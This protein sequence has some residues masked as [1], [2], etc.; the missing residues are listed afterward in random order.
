MP[1][2]MLDLIAKKRDGF[3]HSKPELEFL[4]AAAAKGSV[5]DY[6]LSAW[7]M[8]VLQRGMKRSE[9]VALTDAMARSGRTL[10]RTSRRKRVDKHSTGGVGDGVSLALA[11]LVAAAGVDVPM[12]S[13]RG[14]G[15]TGGTLDKLESIRGLKVRMPVAKVE[16]IVKS[17]GVC[18]F[19]QSA[20]L[21]PADQKL[22]ALRDAT[23]TVPARPLICGSI[24]SKKIAENLDALVL[25][26]KCGTGAIFQN[27]TEAKSLAEDLIATA[28]ELGLRC[29]GLLTAM[30]QP[31]GRTVGNALEL[32]QA[33]EVLH[34]DASCA[35]YVELTLTLG[36]W[37]LHLAGKARSWDEGA[38][39]LQGRIADRSA[40]DLFRRMVK[41]QGGDPRVAEEPDRL[42]LAKKTRLVRADRAGCLARLD[43]LTTGRAGVALGA[44][45]DK[46]DDRLDYGA[47]I[48]LL[49]KV[50]DHVK[51]GETIAR[52]YASDAVRLGRGASIFFDAVKISPR[53]TMAP[54]VIRRIWR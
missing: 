16:R 8:A 47:G 32:R 6:Q 25:D 12:M 3:A 15:H 14:L 52:L 36:G 2:R 44:G 27:E 53:R 40:L 26:I 4:S 23:A 42:K 50:G 13:G 29:V 28:E 24:L 5:P 35:D 1:L 34:G 22:Y 21:A 41:A 48:E 7:L 18:M 11:P 33:I 45:R 43:A 54:R 46:M 49:K 38:E 39:L 30:D 37:M 9:T 17:L 10:K 51:K 19:G 20:D 31:L